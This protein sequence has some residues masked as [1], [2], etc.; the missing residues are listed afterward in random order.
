MKT[1]RYFTLA[2]CFLVMAI[3]FLSCSGPVGTDA[4]TG[5][6]KNFASGGNS[7]FH[8]TEPVRMQQGTLMLAGEV[9]VAG[10][11]DLKGLYERETVVREARHDSSGM[12]LVGAYRYKGY[13][14]LDLLNDNVLA[15]K[16]A[17]LFRPAIDLYLIVEN[18]TGQRVVFSWSEIFHT[19][20][21][22]QIMIATAAAPVLPYKREVTYPVSPIWRIV[23]ADDLNNERFLENPSKIT[24]VSFDKKEYPINREIKPLFSSAID[25]RLHDSIVAVLGPDQASQEHLH[26]E[27]TFY[28]MGMGYHSVDGFSGPSVEVLLKPFTA[29]L[30]DELSGSGL[31][32]FSGL[33]GY[34]TVFSYSELFNRADGIKAILAV[35]EEEGGMFRLFHPADFFADRSV[36]ALQEVYIFQP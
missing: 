36:K 4:L 25:V 33:D 24:V 12:A 26:Y 17:E 18:E 11:I 28:G 35:N 2:I 10:P 21:P 30:H 32:C 14:L 34:R 6:S 1:M 16:N 9:T 20:R 23:A 29:H 8:R 19:A 27:T 5:A 22:H 31:V 15:K 3:G 7:L 13:S